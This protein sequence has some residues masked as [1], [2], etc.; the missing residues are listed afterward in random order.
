MDF[1]GI[2]K[3][4]GFIG[5]VVG[6][7]FFIVWR[8]LVWVMAFVKDIIKQQTEERQGWRCTLDKHNDLITKISMSIDEHDK[9]ADER[10]G[11]VRDEHKQM[12]TNLE[13]QAK[14]L[15]RI[16]GYKKE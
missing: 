6:A 11:Y 4:Y 10:G 3:E 1:I 13:E 12:I 8:M 16:N 15:A 14:T 7:L 9:R 5:L 2:F